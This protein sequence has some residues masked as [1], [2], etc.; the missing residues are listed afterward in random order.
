VAL[1]AVV[2]IC[3]GVVLLAK[4][5]ARYLSIPY[6]PTFLQQVRAGNVV[7][8]SAAVGLEHTAGALAR[9]CENVIA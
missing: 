6:T 5:P 4:P 2:A 3:V 9:P 7:T 8:V 1:L